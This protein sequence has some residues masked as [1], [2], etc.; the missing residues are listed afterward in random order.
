MGAR[1]SSMV[2]KPSSSSSRVS[3]D[4][5]KTMTD[6]DAN[7]PNNK[8][9]RI[10]SPQP[11]GFDDLPDEVLTKVSRYLS[12]NSRVLLAV[13]VTA[14]SSA[15]KESNYNIKPSDAAK[16]I[17]ANEELYCNAVS[18]GHTD[19][20]LATELTDEEFGGFLACADAVHGVKIVSLMHCKLLVGYGLE[21]LRSCTQVESIVLCSGEEND[22]SDGGSA[23]I[24]LSK[25]VVIPILESI[26]E[27]REKPLYFTL[28]KTWCAE[29]SEMVVSF[30]Q[31]Y[32]KLMNSRNILCCS[33]PSDE[34][35]DGPGCSNICR[36]TE[37]VP[38]VNLGGDKF[39]MH[40]LICDCCY[41]T[42]CGECAT[43]FTHPC[44]ACK[45]V[46]CKQCEGTIKCDLCQ[47]SVGASY[48]RIYHHKSLTSCIA[49]LS[50]PGVL[51]F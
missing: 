51:P 28:P 16:V 43:E 36:G 30:L 24:Y 4:K 26:I 31:K 42:Y 48:L 21:P 41:E 47:V 2:P 20:D 22:T 46:G 40:N 18:F 6:E 37:E 32:N 23:E 15:W 8:R 45:M 34:D 17:L 29:Q 27:K 19:K 44:V 25:E 13:A 39:A 49:P 33:E 35:E 1:Y 38:W 3:G 7:T 12:S 50:L 10:M 11:L 9:A 5:K 14:S